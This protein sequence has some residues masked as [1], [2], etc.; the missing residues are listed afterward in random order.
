[1]FNLQSNNDCIISLIIIK[2]LYLSNYQLSSVFSSLRN[3]LLSYLTKLTVNNKYAGKRKYIKSL[4]TSKT[5]KETWRK[6]DKDGVTI[7]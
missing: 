1:M 2:Q 3:S 4:E 7:K 5:R 6:P